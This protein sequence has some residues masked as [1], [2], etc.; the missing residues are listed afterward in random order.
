M[1]GSLVE[2]GVTQPFQK[3]RPSHSS[4]LVKE[5]HQIHLAPTQAT[6]RPDTGGATGGGEPL[7]PLSLTIPE[8]HQEE[9]V[10][11]AGVL[12]SSM[13]VSSTPAPPRLAPKET[14]KGEPPLSSEQ[15]T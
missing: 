15:G 8:P 12:A 14:I 4:E 7:T 6:G 11:M 1:D 5:D 9:T 2:V 3:E 10:I 13:V